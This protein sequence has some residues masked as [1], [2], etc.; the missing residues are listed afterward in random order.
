MQVNRNKLNKDINCNYIIIVPEINLKMNH[1]NHVQRISNQLK[2][3]AVEPVHQS[4]QRFFL[5]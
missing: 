4:S 5:N 3:I 1:L 2:I